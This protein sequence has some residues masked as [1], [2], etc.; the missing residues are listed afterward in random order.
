MQCLIISVLL[1][2]EFYT[3]KIYRSTHRIWW[4]SLLFIFSTLKRGIRPLR[5]D[6]SILFTLTKHFPFWKYKIT[7]AGLWVLENKVFDVETPFLSPCSRWTGS[8]RVDTTGG[9]ALLHPPKQYHHEPLPYILA[10]LT[11]HIQTLL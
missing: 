6:W 11:R 3:I 8:L 9:W 4:E 7:T 1:E 10:S 2:L 5:K